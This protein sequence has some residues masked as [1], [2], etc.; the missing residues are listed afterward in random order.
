[1]KYYEIKYHCGCEFQ[2]DDSGLQYADE[3]DLLGKTNA[4]I[5]GFM[6]PCKLH[7]KNYNYW[8]GMDGYG[9]KMYWMWWG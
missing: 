6:K 9:T 8:K 4:Q 2:A 3:K 7:K 1:M 5:K